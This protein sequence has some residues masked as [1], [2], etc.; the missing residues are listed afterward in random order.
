MPL[1][2][3]ERVLRTDGSII[4][5]LV[6]Q[7]S[8]WGAYYED[9]KSKGHPFYGSARFYTLENVKGLLENSGLEISRIKSTLSQR[10]DE[11]RRI[12]E[13]VEG[14]IIGAGFLCI[15]AKKGI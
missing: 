11:S 8:P 7:D 2:E 14:R 13:P 3:A 15:E 6:P 1:R 4:L 10:P 12:E 9:K 5:G